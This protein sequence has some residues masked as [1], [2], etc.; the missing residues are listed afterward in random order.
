MSFLV[1]IGIGYAVRHY[2]TEI[3]SFF[4]TVSR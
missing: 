2:Q 1:A 3:V 4:R